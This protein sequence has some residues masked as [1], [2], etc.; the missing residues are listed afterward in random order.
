GNDYLASSGTL[1]FNGDPTVLTQT[2]IITIEIPGDRIVELDAEFSVTL[3]NLTGYGR[4]DDD[5]AQITIEDNDQATI[6]INDVIVNEA[7]GKAR[8]TV[9]LDA[10][11]ST[12]V[13][14]DYTTVDQSATATNDYLSQTGSLTFTPGEL[15]QII[16]IDLVDST[17][18]ELPETFLVQLSNLQAGGLDV[19]LP[20]DLATVTIKDDDIGDYELK[21][22]IY[23]IGSRHPDDHF[24][25]SLAVD[26]DTLISSAPGWDA[27]YS[28]Q[29]GAFIYVRNDQGTPEYTG[30]DTWEYQATLLAPDADNNTSDR[31]G[32]VVAISGDTAVVAAL[33]GDETAENA[34]SVFVFTRSNGIWSFQQELHVADTIG[35][36]YFGDVVAIENDTIVVG[37]RSTDVYTGSAY[38]FKRENN[39]WTQTAKLV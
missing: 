2:K 33:Y 31:F 32:H 23:S 6:S 29:G 19:F 12:T 39:V 25:F 1:T 26:G 13:T 27:T 10:P 8:L 20:D 21:S 7:A 17:P 5:T 35:N 22:Q 38:V 28:D 14:L 34:G 24:G 3:S 4:L 36:G 37:A 15:S 16:E 9:V 18:V 30:D 11:V